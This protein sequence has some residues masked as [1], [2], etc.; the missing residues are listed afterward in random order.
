MYRRQ[1]DGTPT[2]L[3]TAGDTLSLSTSTEYE[4]RV[5]VGDDPG[6]STLQQLTFTVDTDRDGDYSDETAQIVT[7]AVDDVWS[8]GCV[9][10]YRAAGGSA[11][12]TFNDV[13]VWLD[14]DEDGILDAADDVQVADSF[15]SG[16]I[17]LSYDNNGNLTDDGLLKYVYDA[18]NRLVKVNRSADGDTTT[19]ATYAYDGQN[20][21]TQKVVEKCGPEAVPGTAAVIT[22]S[23]AAGIVAPHSRTTKY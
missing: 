5:I 4:A 15:D 21:R 19:I 13:K 14:H 16:T 8:A 23:S 7:T 1:D 9:G 17:S 12:Q 11:A 18:W 20:R 22:E 6:D 3:A 2:T 10:L